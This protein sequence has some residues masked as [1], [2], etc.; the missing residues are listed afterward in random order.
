MKKKAL[1][2][3]K[4]TEAKLHRIYNLFISLLFCAF[5]CT[6]LINGRKA[7]LANTQ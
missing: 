3:D 2:D 5:T 1:S 6:Y 4:K 7:S